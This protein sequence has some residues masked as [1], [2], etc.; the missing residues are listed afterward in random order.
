MKKILVTGFPHCGTTILRKIIGNHPKILDIEKE[1][2]TINSGDIRRAKQLGLSGVVIKEPFLLRLGK[3]VHQIGAK[4]HDYKIIMIIRNPADITA[5]MN[6]RFNNDIPNHHNFDKWEL[7]ARAYLNHRSNFAFHVKYEE[8]FENDYAKIKEIFEWLG[9]EWTDDVIH[10][11][12]QRVIKHNRGVVTR[13]GVVPPRNHSDNF[14]TWQIN[15]KIEPMIGVNA[16]KL[17]EAS[18]ALIKESDYA[19]QLGYI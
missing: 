10:T 11:N 12:E 13:P 14:R 8:L 16:D 1:S 3:N 19:K 17:D 15:Q 4:Y 5:S 18:A 7:Y 2:R 6:M 9:L